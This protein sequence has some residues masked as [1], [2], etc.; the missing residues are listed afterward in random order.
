MDPTFINKIEKLLPI[1][2]N[3]TGYVIS[4]LILFL[5]LDVSIDTK[6]HI[7]IILIENKDFTTAFNLINDIMK[8]NNNFTDNECNKYRILQSLCIEHVLN[9][10]VNYN[11]EIIASMMSSLFLKRKNKP[12]IMVTMTT[13][14]RYDLFFKTVSSFLNCCEDLDMIDDWVVIDDNSSE[15][16]RNKMM[17]NFPFISYIFKP[18]N[19]AGHPKSMN[20][21]QQYVLQKGAEY[22]F[23]IEDDWLFFRKEKYISNCLEIL[24]NNDNYGQCLL[25]RSYGERERCIDI[26]GSSMFY[27]KDN[28]LRYYVHNFYQG[29]E[30]EQFNQENVGKKQCAYWPHYSFRVGLTKTKVLQDIGLYNEEASHFEMEY[31]HKYINK[32]Y[33]TTF[34]DSIYCYHIGRCT[35]ERGDIDKIN[36][37][38]LNKQPQFG[39]SIKEISN[40]YTT[41]QDSNIK[42][43]LTLEEEKIV[44]TK[45]DV[46]KETKNI[47]EYKIST[48]V[49]NLKRRIDRKKE[50]IIK[51]HD[52]LESLEYSF[53]E[54]VDGQTIKPL[55]KILK[56]FETGD[57]NYRKGIVGCASSHIKLLHNLIVSDADL[58]LIFEDD[59]QL[60]ENFVDKLSSCLQQ[61]ENK[62]WDLLY[63]SHFLYPQYRNIDKDRENIFPKIEKWSKEKCIQ[64][65]MGGN[66][67]YVINKQGAIK[68]YQQLYNNGCYNAIDW[69]MFKQANDMNIYYSYPHIVYSECVTNDI[70]PNSDIQYEYNPICNNRI[71]S[72]LDYW[73][74]KL[75]E[76][77][78]VYKLDERIEDVHENKSS[79][80]IITN[81]VPSRDDILSFIYFI[82]CNEDIKTN[83][84]NLI[85][86]IPVQY[87]TLKNEYVVTIPHTKINQQVLEEIIIGG[88]YLNIDYPI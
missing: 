56:L 9:I 57:Y 58:F 54:G 79:K 8:N 88:G 36:A 70:K 72:E 21:L 46:T 35:F 22:I 52:I 62:N 81:E 76:Q 69:V 15:D 6:T 71:K 23:H 10:N 65:S 31:A 32:G 3:E 14:K 41:T 68:I 86:K 77:G 64:F 30:L 82:K 43:G 13:C 61:L 18:E 74:N 60:T 83:I 34:L 4:K 27:T 53:Y 44:P 26:V 1:N 59:I 33:K 66:F 49:I 25:N 51:N 20:I 28:N 78:V 87:Y 12:K 11:T 48:Y 7:I 17:E 40:I 47:K 5:N 73:M 55:P 84:L 29:I 16:D 45:E 63:L 67:S 50:F 85:K 42:L 38:D 39:N 75:D 2:H 19:E 37:Y 80:I 24:S